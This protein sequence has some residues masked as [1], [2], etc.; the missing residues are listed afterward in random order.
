VKSSELSQEIAIP[1]VSCDATGTHKTETLAGI[2]DFGVGTRRIEMDVI[3]HD[4]K[5]RLAIVPACHQVELYIWFRLF[6][7]ALTLQSLGIKTE[8]TPNTMKTKNKTNTSPDQNGKLSSLKMARRCMAAMS[9]TFLLPAS[10]FAGPKVPDDWKPY[11]P[12]QFELNKEFRMYKSHGTIL[13]KDSRGGELLRLQ[14][15]RVDLT[16][17]VFSGIRTE[18]QAK[19]LC[20]LLINGATVDDAKSYQGLLQVHREVGKE[21]LIKDEDLAFDRVTKPVEGGFQVEFTALHLPITMGGESIVARYKFIV[22]KDASVKIES[23]PYLK[24]IALNWQT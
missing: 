24:G 12:E 10:A 2:P 11:G 15:E 23:T 13:V 19:E 17:K 1:G 5:N 6:F 8:T 14:L 20:E 7:P 21:Q 18:K 3:R 22:G 9:L 16:S 4:F